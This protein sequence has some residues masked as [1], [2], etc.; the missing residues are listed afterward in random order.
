MQ[1]SAWFAKSNFFASF[2]SS[3]L[4]SNLEGMV[5]AYHLQEKHLQNINSNRE[6][7]TGSFTAGQRVMN[8]VTGL[9][10]PVNKEKYYWDETPSTAVE[11][12]SCRAISYTHTPN[13]M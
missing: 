4:G 8:Q 2:L 1:S 6:L 13:K 9:S 3:L 11:G 5:R 7:E 10:N 12:N